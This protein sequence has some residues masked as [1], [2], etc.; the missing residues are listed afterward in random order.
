MFIRNVNKT[1]NKNN[2]LNNITF[3]IKNENI[4]GLVGKNGAGKT[5]LLKILNGNMPIYRGEV[6]GFSDKK[7]ASIIEKPKLY[8]NKTGRFN[9]TFFLKIQDQVIDW[10]FV[11]HLINDFQ[12]KNYINRKVNKYS[13]GMKQL[14]SLIIAI[15][16]RPDLLILDEPTNGMDAKNTQ[17]VLSHLTHIAQ[18]YNMIIIIT[19]HKLEEIEQICERVLI[20]ENGNLIKDINLK[21]KLYAKRISLWFLKKDLDDAIA[22]IESKHRLI[23]TKDSYI[24]C[25]IEEDYYS[26]LKDLGMKNIYPLKTKEYSYSLKEQYLDS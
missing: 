2:V 20:M 22:L 13:M 17:K 11:E 24:E 26:L 9:L 6:S 15:A 18:K 21:N 14:L 12:M 3:N 25:E 5:T 4:V 19:S 16:Q 10:E 7:I 23:T 8:G 1:Y